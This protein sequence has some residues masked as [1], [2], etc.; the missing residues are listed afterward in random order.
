MLL[1]ILGIKKKNLLRNYVLSEL[2]GFLSFVFLFV[3]VLVF[4][5]EPKL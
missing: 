1:P 5:Q 4:S 2:G 3:F